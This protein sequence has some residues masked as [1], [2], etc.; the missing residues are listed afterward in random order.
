MSIENDLKIALARPP[1]PGEAFTS[2]VMNRLHATQLPRRRWR[3]PAALVASLV[4]GISA[5]T[6]MQQQRARARTEHAQQQLLLALE[7]TS[8]H[9]NQV[10]M[11]LSA[12]NPSN[13]HEE[14]GT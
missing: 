4:V 1:D 2:A 9:L 6:L 3:M 8:E 7:I 5:L 11:K 10:Q 13:T 12:P 14:N